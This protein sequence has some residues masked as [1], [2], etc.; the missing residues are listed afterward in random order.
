MG[1]TDQLE[2]S[3]ATTTRGP[4][5]GVEVPIPAE[6][7]PEA[8]AMPASEAT[9]TTGEVNLVEAGDGHGAAGSES[10]PNKPSSIQEKSTF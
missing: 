3:T 1:A 2:A 9:A 5:Q 8:E 7:M 6:G 10:C 4:L